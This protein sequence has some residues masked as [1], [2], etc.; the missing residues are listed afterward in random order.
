MSSSKHFA[1]VLVCIT[2]SLGIYAE[3]YTIRQG[4]TLYSIARR[5]DVDVANIVSENPG[6]DIHALS[7][8]Q[9][10][11]IPQGSGG[12]SQGAFSTYHVQKGDTLYS[13]ARRFAVSLVE[14]QQLNDLSNTHIRVGM[15]LRIPQAID[16]GDTSMGDL[17]TTNA[18]F[19]ETGYQQTIDNA[20]AL[21]WPVQ[22]TVRE[23]SGKFPGVSIATNAGSEGVAVAGGTV[24]YVG[25]HA[26]FGNII[27]V[28]HKNGYVYVYAGLDN[29]I[30]RVGESIESG[31]ALGVVVKTVQAEEP[32]LYFSVWKNDR[33]VDPQ[34]APRG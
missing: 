29:P 34:Y 3:P 2:F 24:T 27:F 28:Q 19:S 13:I 5:F 33:Y 18:G 31:S 15:A 23:L 16:Q 12:T 1:L 32:Q 22:G 6:I 25:A 26:V 21:R 11:Q 7:I 4:D 30:V 17:L 14:L 10:I 20:G 9:N 8:G